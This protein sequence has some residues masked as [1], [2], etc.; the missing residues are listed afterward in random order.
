MMLRHHPKLLLA[1]LILMFP[2]AL[3]SAA[4][5]SASAAPTPT[6]QPAPVRQLHQAPD[7]LT[8]RPAPARPLRVPNARG[9][10]AEKAAANAAAAR[11]SSIST[12]STLAP[13]LLRNW[14]GQRD[15][16]GAP[17]DS[18]G[19]IG[20]TRYVELVNARVGIYSRTSNTPTASG[21]LFQLTGCVTT[22]CFF[23]NAF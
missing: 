7:H 8:P 23:D 2:A 6:S 9:Y 15:T 11:R 10:A 3:V 4:A 13:T 14:A 18:T 19:A 5:G 20:T 1:A 16:T 12:P 21:T 22:D 17:S